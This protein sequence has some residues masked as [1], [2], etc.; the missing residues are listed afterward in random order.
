VVEKLVIVLDVDETLIY[1]STHT[2]L[3]RPPDFVL[4][5]EYFTHIRPGAIDFL[6]TIIADDRFRVGIYSKA[7]GDYIL[8]FITGVGLKESDFELIFDRSRL[9]KKVYDYGPW[10]R[11]RGIEYF[12]DLKKV[13][14][15]LGCHID[16]MV[17]IDDIP[18]NYPRSY[19][20][21]LRVPEYVGEC[22]DNIF[23][24]LLECLNMLY[25]ADD[26]RQENKHIY[27]NY[28]T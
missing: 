28:D 27:D 23:I 21:V 13:K 4:G 20:N 3:N 9:V 19:G 15:R 14:R 17:A 7:T 22:D 10:A 1:S 18:S 2:L 12:K 25:G 16:R 8:E 11:G 26:V 5:G 6:K 24:K